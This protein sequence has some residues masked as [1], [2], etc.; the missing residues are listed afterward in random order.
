MSISRLV[1]LRLPDKPQSDWSKVFKRYASQYPAQLYLFND[2]EAQ[3]AGQPLSPPPVVLQE[4]RNGR[5]RGAL[6]RGLTQSISRVTEAT[7][8]IAGGHFDVKLPTTRRD[9]LGR[10]SASINSRSERLS[11]Y[12]YGQRRFLGDVAHEL[13]APIARLQVALSILEQRT[14]EEQY[15]SSL[16]DVQEEIEH[17]ATLVGE[18][19]QSPGRSHQRSDS[20]G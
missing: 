8:R 2:E 15:S 13:S 3:L 14:V 1:A 12:V 4:M 18:V 16:A 10:P 7:T 9:E 19:L 11:G 17:M 5:F 6:G 20:R